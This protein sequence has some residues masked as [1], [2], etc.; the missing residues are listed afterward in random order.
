M[1]TSAKPTLI[2][3]MF[4]LRLLLPVPWPCGQFCL[5]GL[6]S[7]TATAPMIARTAVMVSHIA[8][9]NLLRQ[10]KEKRKSHK[11]GKDSPPCSIEGGNGETGDRN[12]QGVISQFVLALVRQNSFL[13]PSCPCL[14][15]IHCPGFWQGQ[16]PGFTGGAGDKRPG[17]MPFQGGRRRNLAGCALCGPSLTPSSRGRSRRHRPPPSVLPHCVLF[18]PLSVKKAARRTATV[19]EKGGSFES[20][21]LFI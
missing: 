19:K 6:L 20:P 3:P 9:S 16:T 13:H 14:Q 15:R 17:P 2:V 4:I 21:V 1:A 7:Y 5:R 18:C 12:I 11:S 8:I 10:K